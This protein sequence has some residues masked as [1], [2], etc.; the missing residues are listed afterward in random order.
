MQRLTQLGSGECIAAVADDCVI[1]S[2]A[3]S[4]PRRSRARLA[5]HQ[6]LPLVPFRGGARC[7]ETVPGMLLNNERLLYASVALFYPL[8]A[9]RCTLTVGHWVAAAAPLCPDLFAEI[10]VVVAL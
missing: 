7:A 1:L 2:V 3:R 4:P 9:C 8:A 10:E 5:A 6:C